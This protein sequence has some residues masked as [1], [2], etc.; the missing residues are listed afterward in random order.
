LAAGIDKLKVNPSS[1]TGFTENVSL[2]FFGQLKK[3]AA[4]VMRVK[5]LSPNYEKRH[6]PVYVRGASFDGFDGHAWSRTNAQ[7]STNRSWARRYGGR[8]AFA[9][10]PHRQ[11]TAFDFSIYPINLNIVFTIGTPVFIDGLSAG[12]Y[13]DAND[14][15]RMATPYLEGLRYRA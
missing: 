8:M 7:S 4:R 5:P 1:I 12:A 3:S 9:A 15:V 10:R 11:E 6:P 2:G 13:F 14:T